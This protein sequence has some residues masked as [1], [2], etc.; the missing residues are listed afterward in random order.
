MF[1][2]NTMTACDGRTYVQIW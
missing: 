1:N 2:H